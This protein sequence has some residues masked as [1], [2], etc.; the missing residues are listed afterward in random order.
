MPMA[1][2]SR[3]GEAYTLLLQHILCGL[4]SALA[5]FM[6]HVMAAVLCW[7]VL[8]QQNTLCVLP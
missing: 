5:G 3:L 1:V 4:T 8:P 7:L 6:Q 2:G